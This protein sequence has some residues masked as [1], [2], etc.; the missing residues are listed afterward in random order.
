MGTNHIYLIILNNPFYQ[1]VSPD[2]GILY[3]LNDVKYD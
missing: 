1:E 3:A 2:F